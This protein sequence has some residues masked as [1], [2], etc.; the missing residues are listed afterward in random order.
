MLFE[1]VGTN[2]D[3][4]STSDPS[5][6]TLHQRVNCQSCLSLLCSEYRRLLL[7][8]RLHGD[9]HERSLLSSSSSKPYFCNL[10]HIYI[11]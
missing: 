8:Y 9:L 11:I 6:F 4:Q 1:S 7:H 3:V 10:L 5:I 2:E